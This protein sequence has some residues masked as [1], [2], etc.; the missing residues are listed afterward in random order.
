M[1][2]ASLDSPDCFSAAERRLG[3]SQRSK[4]LPISEQ[5][6]HGGVIAL[7]QIISPLSIDVSDTVEVRIILVIDL[8]NDASIAVRLVRH[9]F[10]RPVQEYTLDGLV[11]KGPCSLR[12]TA[13]GETKVNHL[14]VGIDG[15]PR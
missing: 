14:A 3:R 5:P 7:D 11:E 9:N 15:A 2:V 6:F 12:I 8:T 13:R 4:A 10:N 1:D